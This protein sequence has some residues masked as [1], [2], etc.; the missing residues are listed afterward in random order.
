MNICYL[1]RSLSTRGGTENYVYNMSRALAGLGHNVHIVSSTGKGQW[2]FKGLED[3]IFIHQFDFQ[4]QAL[5]GSWR[6]EG[7]FPLYA[8][9]YGHLVKKILPAI[10]KKHAIDIIEATDW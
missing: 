3:K 10:V 5:A 9:R 6:L 1:V 4:D 7:V 2:D 8:W